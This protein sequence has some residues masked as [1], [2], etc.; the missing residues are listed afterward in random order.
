MKSY[1]LITGASSG[2]GKEYASLL[3]QKGYNLVLVAR[4]ADNLAALANNL[5]VS[6]GVETV[7]VAKDLSRYG[8]AQEVYDE[9]AAMGIHVGYLVNNA[10]IG[11]FGEFASQD[12]GE[13]NTLL[14]L[15][16]TALVNLTRL[17]IPSMKAQKQGKILNV[18]SIASFQPVPL[19]SMY[20]ASKAFVL[21][22]SCSLAYELRGTGI[23]VSALCPPAFHSGFQKQS[24]M[25]HSVN[26]KGALMPVAAI[27]AAG[28][29]G[30]ER[31]KTVIVPGL[32]NKIFYYGVRLSPLMLVM[33]IAKSKVRNAH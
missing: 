2:L 27:A 18:A 33:A 21:N 11:V 25:E 30:V 20:S 1:A 4:N 10:G 23:S 31:K 9:V 12:L 6:Y 5:A 8:A 17:F 22:F 16:I 29:N 28:Y 19:F 7:C 13:I 32:I 24:K 26:F 3:A 15:N 14:M